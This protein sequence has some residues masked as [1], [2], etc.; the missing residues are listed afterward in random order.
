[1][2]FKELVLFL[3]SSKDRIILLILISLVLIPGMAII[4]ERVLN[5]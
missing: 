3:F 5:V 1:M 2:S 4:L